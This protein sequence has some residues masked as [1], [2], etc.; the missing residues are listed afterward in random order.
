MDIKRNS[1]PSASEGERKS[2]PTPCSILP[3]VEVHFSLENDFYSK[4]FPY[5]QA[6]LHTATATHQEADA[7][8]TK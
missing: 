4:P 7:Q 1:G 8:H 6:I 3:E 2:P 5:T